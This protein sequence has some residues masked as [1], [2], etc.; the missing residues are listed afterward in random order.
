[1]FR[2]F[3]IITLLLLSSVYAFSQPSVTF[4]PIESS[5]DFTNSWT[6][7]SGDAIYLKLDASNDPVLGDL[8]VTGSLTVD[9]LTMDGTSIT[10]GAELILDL[11]DGQYIQAFPNVTTMTNQTLMYLAPPT[12]S[13]SGNNSIIDMSPA[14]SL[15]AFITTFTGLSA[16]G[17]YNNTAASGVQWTLFN[18]IPDLY[19]E[20]D[21]IVPGSS[22]LWYNVGGQIACKQTA[23]CGSGGN[24]HGFNFA[25][26]IDAENTSTMTTTQVN[27]FTFAPT[28]S[29][30]SGATHTIT[31]VRGLNILN[32]SISGSPTVTTLTGVRISSLTRGTTNI[33][34]SSAMT[35]GATNYFIRATGT[36]RSHFTGNVGIGTSVPSSLLEVVGGNIRGRVGVD[37]IDQAGTNAGVNFGAF[38]NTWTST[39]GTHTWTSTLDGGEFFTI[40]DSDADN[41]SDTTLMRLNFTDTTDANSIFINA[42]DT[43]S[44]TRFKVHNGGEVYAGGISEDGAGKAVCI[45]ADKTLGTCTDAVGAAGTCTCS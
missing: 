21:A 42:T 15:D 7:T 26:V 33:G 17:S 40:S 10:S 41:A 16:A 27:G 43:N 14:A 5:F 8:A 35:A 28:V 11:G 19:S 13:M 24:Y 9:S 32:P 6:A 45:K 4:N 31:D 36:A 30:A 44:Q 34:I 18:A 38:T 29:K 25:P 23:N 22:A 2:K 20:T 3:F 12:V 39:S 37:Y 1:M